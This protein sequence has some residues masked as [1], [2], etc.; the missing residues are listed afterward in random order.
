M[1][2]REFQALLHHWL[3]AEAPT[4]APDWIVQDAVDRAMVMDRARPISRTWPAWQPLA[5]LLLVPL[6]LAAVGV[7]A[8]YGLLPRPPDPAPTPRHEVLRHLPTGPGQVLG[9]VA[10]ERGLW[11]ASN[12][13]PGALLLDPETGEVL[14]EVMT[15]E[16]PAPRL[17]LHPVVSDV[18]VGFGAVWT[19]DDEFGS[20]TR[21]DP[22]T[23]RQ[24]ETIEVGEHPRVAVAAAGG[25]WVLA[26]V[27]GILTRIDPTNGE[28]SRIELARGSL[29]GDGHLAGNDEAIW[30][31]LEEK[32]IQI[33][34][35]TGVA[36]SSVSLGAHIRGVVA[37]GSAAWMISGLGLT[38]VS[39]TGQPQETLP[40]GTD[41]G[42]IALAG[43]LVWVAD[44]RDNTIR[45]FDPQTRT[46]VERLE[47]GSGA[48]DVAV[49]GSTMVVL[50]QVDRTVTVIR[51]A[52]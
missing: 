28:I 12:D 38:R 43:G 37:D 22:V 35:G 6:L 15:Y 52:N 18:V 7:A 48:T 50:N 8:L 46:V 13:L 24:T 29:S 45:G 32:L 27:N 1:N 44:L 21:I 40:I 10:D 36:A 16:Q 4:E 19:V 41:P 11:L 9:V 31:A 14:A 33:H 20:V 25:L 51:L 23:A 49:S 34:P 42:A 26:P 5:A 30:I 3:R 2:E 39:P 47:I 17:D